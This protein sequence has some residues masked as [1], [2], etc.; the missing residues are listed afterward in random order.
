MYAISISGL[1][2]LRN[3]LLKLSKSMLYVVSVMPLAALLIT[4]GNT[5]I[6]FFLIY[7]V[8]NDHVGLKSY[9]F[10]NNEYT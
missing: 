6:V 7:Y 5:I 4:I 1:F 8:F 9:Y 10:I 3:N 2:M